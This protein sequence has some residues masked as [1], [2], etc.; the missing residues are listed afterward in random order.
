MGVSRFPV[1]VKEVNAFLDNINSFKGRTYDEYSDQFF[2]FIDDDNLWDDFDNAI[3]PAANGQKVPL[4]A[5]ACR[6]A[7]RELVAEFYWECTYDGLTN[8]TKAKVNREFGKYRKYFNQLIALTFDNNKPLSKA[9]F[10]STVNKLSD[11][12]NESVQHVHRSLSTSE[13]VIDLDDLKDYLYSYDSEFYEDNRIEGIDDFG[14]L[15]MM[16]RDLVG[17]DDYGSVLKSLGYTFD[18]LNKSKSLQTSEFGVNKDP[19]LTYS[20]WYDAS[21]E[22]NW[23]WSPKDNEDYW[24]FAN[25]V[26]IFPAAI[27]LKDA[28][29]RDIV[30]N[31]YKFYD[32]YEV[33]SADRENAFL[34]ASETLGIEY[35]TLYNSWLDGEPI[36][37][38]DDSSST[39]QVLTEATNTK[40]SNLIAKANEI[41]KNNFINDGHSED[42]GK[43]LVLGSCFKS[44]SKKFHD[45]ILVHL[46]YY[47]KENDGHGNS[48]SRW[49]D[50]EFDEEGNF[51]T[52]DSTGVLFAS[53]LRTSR[54]IRKQ[55]TNYQSPVPYLTKTLGGYDIERLFSCPSIDGS[56]ILI[57]AIINKHTSDRPYIVGLYYNA[58]TGEWDNGLY[59]AETLDDAIAKLKAYY[60]SHKVSPLEW[61]QAE[62]LFQSFESTLNTSKSLNTGS[63]NFLTNDVFPLIVWLDSTSDTLDFDF[64]LVTNEVDKFN[65]EINDLADSLYE[66]DNDSYQA[67]R[68]FNFVVVGG[69]NDGFQVIPVSRVDED[70]WNTLSPTYYSLFRD[71]FETLEVSFG[72]TF[73]IQNGF[74][75][76]T[77]TDKI[78][79]DNLLYGSK[80]TRL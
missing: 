56:G 15:C 59:G 79:T 13:D 26:K 68:T 66:E 78:P 39:V 12:L 76:I 14:I 29:A 74:R 67:L 60:P 2:N 31:A 30:K 49:N 44:S 75:G 33:D 23:G 42:G 70:D 28:T 72:G 46:D 22:F 69:Y 9:D 32:V 34:F 61:Y 51:V 7:F 6:K 48:I 73:A 18:P 50:I 36:E 8:N 21:F 38:S 24:P 11:N 64:E 71:F 5:S 62:R 80:P 53:W 52:D 10:P 4:S 43:S 16:L 45:N 40:D 63:A 54:S 55:N 20:Q 58:Y 77:L 3:S 25:Y 35:D 1:T 37:Y 41:A 57:H 27:V 17:N 47:V 19:S 65:Q